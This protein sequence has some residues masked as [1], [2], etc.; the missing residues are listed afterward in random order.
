MKDAFLD[1]AGRTSPQKDE[2][3]IHASIVAAIDSGR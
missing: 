1:A 3:M 2:G